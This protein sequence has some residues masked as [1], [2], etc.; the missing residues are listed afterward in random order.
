[1]TWEVIMAVRDGK[2]VAGI[3]YF[4]GCQDLLIYDEKGEAKRGFKATE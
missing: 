3:H 1:M 4:R 2:K